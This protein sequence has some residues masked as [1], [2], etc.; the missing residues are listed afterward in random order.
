MN[1]MYSFVWRKPLRG[2]NQASPPARA[3]AA[4]IQPNVGIVQSTFFFLMAYMGD[5]LYTCFRKNEEDEE[6][7]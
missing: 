3:L 7:L 5:D 2:H 6:Q 4:W 1:P